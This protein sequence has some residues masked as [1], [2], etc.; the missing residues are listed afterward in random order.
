VD[1]GF[2][3]GHLPSGVA[4]DEEDFHGKLMESGAGEF[5]GNC[6]RGLRRGCFLLGCLH[7]G[8]GVLEGEAG[9]F[10][11]HFLIL[12]IVEAHCFPFRTVLR[13]DSEGLEGFRGGEEAGVCRVV[14]PH[15]IPL[16]ASPIVPCTV[17]ET[18]EGDGRGFVHFLVLLDEGLGTRIASLLA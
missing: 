9:F 1:E 13:E 3:H 11:F 7:E 17:N 15:L 5:T 12:R 14:T 8:E 6:L 16:E 2:L 18:V 4:D 10:A